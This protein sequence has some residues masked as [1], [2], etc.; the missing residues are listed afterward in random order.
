LAPIRPVPHTDPLCDR[1]MTPSTEGKRDRERQKV[2]KAQA[3]AERR[4]SRQSDSGEIPPA[5][6]TRTEEELIEQLGSLQ[7]SLEAGAIFP[8]EYE[9][10]RELLQVEFGQ[11]S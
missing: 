7:R 2:E 10:R 3:K 8:E 4:A 6:S 11:L 1:F 9:Y 5:A